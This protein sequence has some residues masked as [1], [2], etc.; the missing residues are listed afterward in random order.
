MKDAV[1]AFVS[2]GLQS[3]P[4]LQSST[5]HDEM[6]TTNSSANEGRQGIQWKSAQIIINVRQDFDKTS[7]GMSDAYVNIAL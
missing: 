7:S 3:Q 6:K 4:Q 5:L 1:D 2:A